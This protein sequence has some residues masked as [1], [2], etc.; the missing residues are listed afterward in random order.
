MTVSTARDALDRVSEICGLPP[1]YLAVHEMAEISAY[2]VYEPTRGGV[3]VIIGHDGSL[4]FAT[5]ALSADQA[6][7]LYKS[8]RRTAVQE[9]D[10]L[11]EINRKKYADLD[12]LDG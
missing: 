6:T 2:R 9:F 1:A 10:G 12:D 8:G 11:R 5:S 7:E 4:M 3:R